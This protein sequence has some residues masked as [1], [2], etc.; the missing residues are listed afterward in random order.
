[1]MITAGIFSSG[2]VNP[3]DQLEAGLSPSAPGEHS[4]HQVGRP[5]SAAPRRGSPDTSKSSPTPLPFRRQSSRF[6]AVP[7]LQAC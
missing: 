4:Q 7:D 5:A 2:S 1:M 6:N 3:S